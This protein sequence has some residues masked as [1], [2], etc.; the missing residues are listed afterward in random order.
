MDRWAGTEN[1]GV[2]R[3]DFIKG[4]LV[5]G[6]TAAAG[7]LLT[8]APAEPH[9]ASAKADARALELLLLVEQTEVAFY[10]EAVEGGQLDGEV[11]EY[12]RQVLGQEREHLAFI[13][14]ALGKDP[15]RAPKFDFGGAT[16]DS[17][18]FA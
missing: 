3:T 7:G 18:A 13:E 16:K 12:A 9:A 2:R 8:G 1:S 10:S 6:G 17:D 5:L 14:K 15:G 4:G 11:R